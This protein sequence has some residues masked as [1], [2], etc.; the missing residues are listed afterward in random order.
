MTTLFTRPL[1]GLE[2]AAMGLGCMGLSVNY[3]T[4]PD[5]ARGHRAD[6]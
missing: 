6:P 2:V 3:G 1:G 5:R 4:P